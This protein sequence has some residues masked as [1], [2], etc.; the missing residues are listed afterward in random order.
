MPVAPHGRRQGLSPRTRGNRA[1]L[2][3]L[4]RGAGP[5]P[6]DAGEPI[7]H[8]DLLM[9]GRAYPRGR[10]GTLGEAVKVARLTGLSPRTRGNRL[11]DGPRCPWRGPIPADAGE[12]YRRI[13]LPGYLWAYPR[14][15]GG[16]NQMVERER[17]SE[18]LSPRTRGNP[19]SAKGGVM[20]TGPIPADAGEP[21]S[22]CL[23]RSGARAYPRGR[24]GTTV[25]GQAHADF[26]GLSPRTR[27]NPTGEEYGGGHKGPIPADAGEPLLM[28]QKRKF[29]RAYPRGRGG[30]F[31]RR[32]KSASF[33]G[34]SP[35]TRGNRRRGGSRI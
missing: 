3:R 11:P 4:H 25:G 32:A 8:R 20:P 35:R 33:K 15:R 2:Q 22:R 10:G 30:T 5:I 31:S 28:S 19:P 27:G 14:G 12:P 7:V 13:P 1:F 26:N 9:K 21:I 29:H 16:T 24:G 6:A 17:I 18:G 23:A 34:L